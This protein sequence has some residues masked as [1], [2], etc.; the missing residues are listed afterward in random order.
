MG[1]IEEKDLICTKRIINRRRNKKGEL[2]ELEFFFQPIIQWGVG[3]KHISI[4]LLFYHGLAAPKRQASTIKSWIKNIRTNLSRE[5]I[6][7]L[8]IFHGGFAMLRVL[9]L[10]TG[11]IVIF[12][13]S[14]YPDISCQFDHEDILD[15]P[16]RTAVSPSYTNH[17]KSFRVH[18]FL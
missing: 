2:F 15:K 4:F 8:S 10:S 3:L 13:L 12:L 6:R 14:I 16:K 17:P 9:V 11:P 18:N 5:K 1:G 7:A